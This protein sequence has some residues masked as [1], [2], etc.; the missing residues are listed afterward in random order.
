LDAAAERTPSGGEA[1]TMTR[2]VVIVDADNQVIL[3]EL[4]PEI[5]QEPGRADRGL[6]SSTDQRHH[7]AARV[8]SGLRGGSRP[9]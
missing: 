2:A 3:A 4:V 8:S 1:D 9:R 7:Q 6:F 5:S